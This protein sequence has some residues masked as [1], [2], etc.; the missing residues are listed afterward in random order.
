MNT[1]FRNLPPA[2]LAR[3]ALLTV[4]APFLSRKI[5]VVHLYQHFYIYI[6][7][8]LI[9]LGTIAAA[10]NGIPFFNPYTFTGYNAVE[11]ELRNI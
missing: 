4:R 7:D 1:S 6:F 3:T 11:G 5:T 8:E 2:P 9:F 10:V